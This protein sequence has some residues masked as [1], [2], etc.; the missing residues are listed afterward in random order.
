MAKD[1]NSK[2][3]KFRTNS[4]GYKMKFNIKHL[5][6]LLPSII[7]IMILVLTYFGI[8]NNYINPPGFLVK[9]IEKEIIKEIEKE[10]EI[11]KYVEKGGMKTSEFVSAVNPRVDPSIAEAIGTAVDRYSKE[12]QIPRKLILSIIRKES[13]FN[14]FAKSKVAFG[15]M[16]VFPK[17]HKEKIEALGIKDEREIYHIDNNV[18][19]GCQIFKEYYTASNGNLDETFHKYLSKK[20]TKEQRNAY[21]DAILTSWAMFEMME[22][23]YKNQQLEEEKESV[24]EEKDKEN[25]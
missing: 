23:K 22:Y 1:N 5:Y 3:S 12:Y 16:Q 13:F 6:M 19:L 15:L 25:E 11:I 20:A 14:P 4:I 24:E 10:K 17:F 9:E 2:I 8:T 18:N 7:V 21:R